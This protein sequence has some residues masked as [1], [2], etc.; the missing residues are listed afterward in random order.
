MQNFRIALSVAHVEESDE[1]K[2]KMEEFDSEIFGIQNGS[3]EK[4]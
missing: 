2:T 4:V 1:L 3:V